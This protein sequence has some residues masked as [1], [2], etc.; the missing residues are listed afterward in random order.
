MNEV[1]LGAFTALFRQAC[2]KC[3][4]HAVE[5]P[6]TETGSRLLYNKILDDTGLVVGW[7]SIKNYSFFLL[8]SSAVKQENPSVATLDTLSRY[9]L[10]AAYTTEAERKRMTGQYPYWYRYREQWLQ[11][12]Q[13]VEQPVSPGGGTEG[14]TAALR[15]GRERSGRAW[16][17]AGA[18]F[19][20]S[21][22]LATGLMLVF[23]RGVPP[24]FRDDFHSLGEDSLARRGWLVL[25]RDM[26]YWKRRE[27]YPGYLTLFTL[28]GD[29]W[30]D[31]A[32]SPVIRNLMIR[33]I[34]CDC[35]TIELHL[36]DFIPRENWQQAGVLLSEDTGFTGR[37]MRVSIM[38][39]DYNGVS[40]RSGSILLQAITSPGA[41]GKPEEIAHIPLFSEDSLRK[42]PLLY[43]YLENSALRIEKR[44]ER[45]RILYADGI[46]PT[47]SFKEVV[48]H[49]FAIE[50]RYAGIFALKGFVD[51]TGN[52]PARI[53]FFSLDCESCGT[54]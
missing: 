9:V 25:S 31:P 38:Y 43:R 28:A 14:G 48:S 17:V 5:E 24:G 34:P 53:G 2:L 46:L 35:F 33:R 32:H 8:S 30:P 42:N 36:R 49:N 37:S 39:N 4:G 54:R 15:A 18:I 23:R 26:A 22:L 7:K 11:G 12:R 41:L 27:E 51:S 44:G 29:N 21:A 47:T 1:D 13:A 45:F 40:P 10:G 19:V 20:L 16:L 52:L 6:L 3:F 50:P